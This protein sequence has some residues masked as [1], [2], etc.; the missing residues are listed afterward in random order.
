MHYCGTYLIEMFGEQSVRQD[1]AAGK[2]ITTLAFSE[3]GSRS[4]F[5]A[6]VSSARQDGDQVVLDAEKSWVTSACEADSYV[7]TSKP[8]AAEGMSSLWYLP[9]K[10]AG[11]TMPRPFDGLGLRGN[12][13]APISAKGVVIPASYLL[14]GDGAGFDIMIHQVVPV[15]SVLTASCSLGMI[16]AMM[17]RMIAHVTSVRYQYSD[18]ALAD[19][20]TIRAYIG[21]AQIRADAARAL[22]DDTISAISSARADAMLRILEVRAALAETAL[23]VGDTGMRVCGGAA[24]RKDVG[25]ER[26]FRDSRASAVMGPTSDVLFEFIGRAVCGMPVFG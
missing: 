25:V 9:S 12:A 11:L 8:L 7:W 20:P 18:S 5:W 13:S 23:E 22:R 21:K 17:Q 10:T 15:F 4:H 1:I 16:D 24:F 2:H 14:G 3:N 26:Y 6:P 19:L